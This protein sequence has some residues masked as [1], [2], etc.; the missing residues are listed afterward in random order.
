[1]VI[2]QQQV[3]K[4]SGDFIDLFLFESNFSKWRH[5]CRM[6]DFDLEGE[7]LNFSKN[8]S[9]T[10]ITIMT[11]WHG[12]LIWKFY[13][14]IWHYLAICTP[15]FKKISLFLTVLEQF[16]RVLILF[17]H[18]VCPSICPSMCLSLC[19][20]IGKNILSEPYSNYLIY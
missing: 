16:C 20:G 5:L 8:E 13:M 7:I 6:E 15:I 3:H 4:I 2:I 18:P 14:I 10:K 11:D 1:M 19:T 12:I 9:S 17:C